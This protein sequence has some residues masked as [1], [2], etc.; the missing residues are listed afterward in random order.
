MSTYLISFALILFAI[1]ASKAA[2]MIFMP[3]R[4]GSPQGRPLPNGERSWNITKVKSYPRDLRDVC[5]VIFL[6]RQ[7]LVPDLIPDVLDMAE[8]WVVTSAA[9]ASRKAEFTQSNAGRAYVVASLPEYLPPGSV[10]K[11]V[12]STV[13]RDQG[14]SSFPA[15][16]GTYENS[17]T[18]FE[19]AVYEPDP[20]EFAKIVAPRMKI[21][22]NI[23][24]GKEWKKHDVVWTH[25]S[26]D[27]EVR[28]LIANMRGGQRIAITAWAQY[29]LWRNNV[30][31]ASIDIYTPRFRRG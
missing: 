22:T 31:S 15:Q 4:R 16:H 3:S 9:R 21:V 5:E 26:S 23:H 24:A 1:Y 19:V 28:S 13:S 6:L 10:R 20:Y 2:F 27:E 29:P 8:Y 17:N 30:S 18:W 14:W 11:V 12:F 25:D 7:V